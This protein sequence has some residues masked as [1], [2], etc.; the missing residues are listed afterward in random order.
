MDKFHIYLNV[1]LTSIPLDLFSKIGAISPNYLENTYY[2]PFFSK[3]QAFHLNG[4]IIVAVPRSNTVQKIVIKDFFRK[5][6]KIPRKLHSW[7]HLLKKF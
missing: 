2:V 1:C 5:C 7:S 6:E 4:I 3:V